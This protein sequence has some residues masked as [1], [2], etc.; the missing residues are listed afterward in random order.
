MDR[1][2]RVFRFCW[3]SLAALSVFLLLAACNHWG[4]LSP[5]AQ[6]DSGKLVPVRIG[7]I[8]I[9][10]G[11]ENKTITRAGDSEQRIVGEP[12]VQDLGGGVFAEIAVEEDVSALR[13]GDT[14]LADKVKFRV[15]AV[16][17][18]DNKVYS[19]A[20]YEVNEAGQTMDRTSDEDLHVLDGGSYY[21]VC[22]SHNNTTLP[23]PPSVGDDLSTTPISV[24]AGSND[25]LYQAT[26]IKS[27]SG[28]LNLDF[29]E[30][31]HQLAKVKLKLDGNGKTIT[32]V[33]DNSISLDAPTSEDFNLAEG[34]S[35]NGVGSVV[36][37]GWPGMINAVTATTNNEFRFFPRATGDFML[38][39]QA[40][41]FTAGSALPT[42]A[43]ATFI[44][45][46]KF[47]KGGIYTLSVKRKDL[48]ALSTSFAGSNIYWDD[49]KL[50]FDEHGTT[51][52]QY[53]QGVY[54]KWGSL[55][56]VSPVGETFSSGT[57]A[58]QTS[59]TPIYMKVRE[60]GAWIWKKTNVAYAISKNWFSGSDW[61]AIPSGS[62]AEP[63]GTSAYTV[64]TLH[65]DFAGYLG[66]ICNYID[67]AY[68]MP[69]RD[70]LVALYSS[71]GYT[72]HITSD[73][74]TSSNATGQQAFDQYY[75]A[76]TGT[77][78]SYTLPA[79]GYRD[80]SSGTLNSVG[81]SG[82]YWSDS[83][84]NSS[85]VY[86]LYFDGGSADA[87]YDASRGYGFSVRCVLQE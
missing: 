22:I 12:I 55:I 31:T 66:D 16:N 38:T 41:A 52:H 65:S 18:S 5:E 80:H 40:G 62:T 72:S 74:T 79:S 26:E 42:V 35:S 24:T 58:D 61:D 71:S 86:Y 21:F 68:R 11:A 60:N 20:D 14:P 44:S 63:Y 85:G 53:Y 56:G 67:P 13:A 54:F 34:G 7:A 49:D 1:K 23:D 36:F 75:G 59:G 27:I 82:L 39:I 69:T 76:F 81:Y 30:L 2:M 46:G 9:A 37:T 47:Q 64:L 6:K 87:D 28:S 73:G 70:E 83:A 48:V 19:Y 3:R 32:A 29:K 50:T 10:G 77:G 33:A 43:R 78:T 15:I 8:S 45:A 84:N 17:S 25:L 4:G 51:S 57:V